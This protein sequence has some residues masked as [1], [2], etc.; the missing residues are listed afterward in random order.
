[1]AL[2]GAIR[3]GKALVVDLMGVDMFHVFE[4]RSVTHNEFC[5]PPRHLAAF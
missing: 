2:L 4:M 1:M 5:D 3:F